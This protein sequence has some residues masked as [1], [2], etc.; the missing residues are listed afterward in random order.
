MPNAHRGKVRKANTAPVA[1]GMIEEEPL[2]VP[3]KGWAEMIRKAALLFQ[4][5]EIIQ[6]SSQ[7][8]FQFDQHSRPGKGGF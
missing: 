2:Q 4:I 7:P 5:G 8:I 3:S 6:K 1:W